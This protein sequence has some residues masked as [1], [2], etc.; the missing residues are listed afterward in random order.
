MVKKMT[1]NMTAMDLGAKNNNSSKFACN[2]NKNNMNNPNFPKSSLTDTS[3]H[4]GEKLEMGCWAKF[5]DC[6]GL[7]EK[8]EERLMSEEEGT[9]N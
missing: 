5:M 3:S 1:S 4:N 7:R 6:V 8:Q 9:F 2:N